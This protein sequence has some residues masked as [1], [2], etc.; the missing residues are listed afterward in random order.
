MLIIPGDLK[1]R[2]H[3]RLE[4]WIHATFAAAAGLDIETVVVSRRGDASQIDRMPAIGEAMALDSLDRLLQLWHQMGCGLVPFKPA[5]SAAIF[6]ASGG[7]DDLRR[8]ARAAWETQYNGIPGDGDDATA[9]L[10]WRGQDPFAPPLL[11]EWR[12]LAVV[13]FEQVEH[14]FHS[15]W[16][17]G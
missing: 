1:N 10:S 3:H 9:Q 12:D 15:T 2:A 11:D 7:G 8:R 5:T 14:W 4:A 17:A 13:V 6:K 16:P